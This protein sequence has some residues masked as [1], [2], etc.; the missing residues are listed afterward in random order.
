MRKERLAQERYGRDLGV[1]QTEYDLLEG[2][3]RL[4]RNPSVFRELNTETTVV[5]HKKE[6]VL[7]IITGVALVEP[8]KL[9]GH[10]V[11]GYSGVSFRVMKGVRVHTGSSRGHYEPGPTSP[12]AIAVGDVTVTNQRVVFQSSAQAREFC[13]SKLI[14]YQHDPGLPLTYFQVS[15]RQKVSGIGYGVNAARTWRFRLSLA[16]AAYNDDLPQFAAHIDG[17]VAHQLE[18]KPAPPLLVAG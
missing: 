5:L 17:D 14:G 11:G 12:A 10:W 13:F 4:A 1:W 8:K 18:R 3:Q 16:I 15:N 9:P 7:L 2:E 6:F